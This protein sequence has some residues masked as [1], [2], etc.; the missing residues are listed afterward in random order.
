MLDTR[1]PRIIGDIGNPQSFAMPVRHT[2]IPGAYPV[3]VIRKNPQ[4]LLPE[5]IT[6]GRHL[7]DEG[8]AVITTSCGFLTLFQEE[9]QR[10]LTIPVLTSSL[11]CYNT[12]AAG[13]PEGSHPGILTIAA[14]SLSHA[15]LAAAGISSGCLPSCSCQ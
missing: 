6:T 10:A 2:I 1:F 3:E 15:H 7:Q 12:L 14:S 9:L 5:F 13:L 4:K 11:F 8:A